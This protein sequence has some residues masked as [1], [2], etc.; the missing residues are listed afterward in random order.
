MPDPI[1]LVLVIRQ[2]LS[3]YLN[4]MKNMIRL[5][6]IIFFLQKLIQYSL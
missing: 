3:Q 6:L 2:F 4:N 5:I 1:F